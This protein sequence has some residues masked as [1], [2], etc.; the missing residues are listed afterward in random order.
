MEFA[1]GHYG[2]LEA[3]L[4]FSR[5]SAKPQSATVPAAPYASKSPVDVTFK[6]LNEASVIHYTTDGSAPT[7]SSPIWERQG[8]RRPG[9]IFTFSQTTTVKWIAVDMRGN[10][11]DVQTARFAVDNTAPVT[12]AT[13]APAAVNGWYRAPMV[14][15]TGDDFFDAGGS[16][17]DLTK[18][19]LDGGAWTN[20]VSPF[21]V[22]GDGD[23]T[24]EYYST[25][26]AGNVEATATLTLSIDAT[27]PAIS[28]AQPLQAAS[29]LLNQSV[30]AAY[31]CS[32]ALSG[33]A[34]CVG[35]VPSGSDIDTAS[36]GSKSFAVD[37]LDAAGNPNTFSV[38]YEVRW[39][40]TGFFSPVDAAPTVNVANA[41]SAIPVKFALG[42][43]RGLAILAAGYPK[44]TKVACTSGAPEDSVEQTVTAGGS[45]LTFDEGQY[46]YVWK[47]DKAWA[48]SCRQ[49]EVKLVDG[50]SHKALFR[51]K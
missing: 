5:D 21:P 28:L 45:S 15:L 33:V 23:H 42:G 3:A 14:T 13:V 17:I 43:N 7:L 22:T 38:T 48:G 26:L 16:G 35:T 8:T 31:T 24:I 1:A 27:K 4:A 18:Y 34:S 29:Y 32:D 49:L 20:Y 37:A 50:T 47:S 10:V 19:S 11:S 51:F 2:L 25:D 40:F 36:V 44:S 39:P 41:G 30:P 9:Q 12:S 46:V 6:W